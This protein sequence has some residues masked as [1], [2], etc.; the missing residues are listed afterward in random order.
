[1]R[2]LEFLLGE[3]MAGGCDTV[4]TFGATQSNHAMQTAICANRLGLKAILV[5]NEI[6]EEPEVRANLLLDKILGAEIQVFSE[7][8]GD[9]FSS[10]EMDWV[11][12]RVAQLEGQGHK[13]Y[14][15]P[16]GGATPLG[17]VGF[18]L[19]FCE[20]AGQLRTMTGAHIFHASGTGG[21]AAGLVAAR[22]ALHA[23]TKISSVLV[24]EKP[25]GAYALE[26]ASLANGALGLLGA[27]ESVS[28]ED[29]D[30]VD[31]FWQ[32]GYEMPSEAASEA[33]K[34][35]AREEGLFCDPVYTAKAFAA[36]LAYVREGRVAQGADVVFWHTGGTNALFAD[37]A[38]LGDIY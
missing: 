20:L 30:I 26:C 8:E 16:M 2:K 19:G 9:G 15:I 32:P 10:A 22:A 12:S 21:T 28:E 29:F 13:A 17:C 31:G 6:V 5:L 25:L 33:I 38:I 18:V 11:K 27:G 7:S 36:L 35:V 24:S 23:R 4:F 3:A 14:I 37:K 34:L 1:M